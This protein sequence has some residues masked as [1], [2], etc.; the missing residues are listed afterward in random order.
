MLMGEPL[1]Q[2]PQ[3]T[4]PAFSYDIDPAPSSLFPEQD[5]THEEYHHP[6]SLSLHKPETCSESRD[7]KFSEPVQCCTGSNHDNASPSD[8]ISLSPST[9]KTPKGE[10]EAVD[11]LLTIL[12]ECM[13]ELNTRS[14][15]TLLRKF[16]SE[17]EREERLEQFIVERLKQS[18]VKAIS[19]LCE[20][21]P[22]RNS[23]G[24]S[25]HI[26]TFSDTEGEPVLTRSISES[27]EELSQKLERFKVRTLD[28][29]GPV[30][31]NEE[32]AKKK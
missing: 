1:P 4:R 22:K 8:R 17:I 11:E 32:E 2:F 21:L 27:V 7:T 5:S 24:E 19:D 20:T 30:V 3:P 23:E 10:K 25:D 6:E 29:G 26:S 12:V 15:E 16:F 31:V 28:L 18:R 9:G 13:E 14:R